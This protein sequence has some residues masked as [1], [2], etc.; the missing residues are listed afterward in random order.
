MRGRLTTAGIEFRENSRPDL[1]IH[2]IV[3]HD[4]DG[5]KVELNFRTAAQASS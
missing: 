2:Q 5:I 1:G 3:L 4:P